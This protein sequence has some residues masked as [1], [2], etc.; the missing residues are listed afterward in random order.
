MKKP[1][2]FL[3]LATMTSSLLAQNNS[4]GAACAENKTL[5]TERAARADAKSKGLPETPLHP[6][7]KLLIISIMNEDEGGL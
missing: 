7:E 3:L 1:M 5:E 6:C 2:T 4:K